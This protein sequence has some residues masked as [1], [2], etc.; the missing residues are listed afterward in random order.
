[1][2]SVTG[3]SGDDKLLG[4]DGDDQID[5]QTGTDLIS[6]LGGNDHLSI[7][8]NGATDTI[9]GG[10]GWDGLSLR[11]DGTALRLGA[12]EHIKGI[13]HY[14]VQ[15]LAGSALDLAGS[16][17]TQSV[18]VFDA[19]YASAATTNAYVST[20]GSGRYTLDAGAP[21]VNHWS[22]LHGEWI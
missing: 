7:G 16:K 4:T 20:N 19:L 18:I 3:T 1:M 8:D 6:A 2:S 12:D 17:G 5:G 10:P 21:A 11:V 9:D 15:P 13:E 22:G 14:D